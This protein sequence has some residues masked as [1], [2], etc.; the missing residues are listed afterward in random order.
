MFKVSKY[1]QA[2][3]GTSHQS[4]VRTVIVI[5][6]LLGSC[7]PYW[8]SRVTMKD[9]KTMTSDVFVSTY[10]PLKTL[11]VEEI[12]INYHI[13]VLI[14]IMLRYVNMKIYFIK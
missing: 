3:S 4:L 12:S 5:K 10:W 6:C 7:C 11:F 2:H 14:E 1:S 8:Y 9:L 13:I